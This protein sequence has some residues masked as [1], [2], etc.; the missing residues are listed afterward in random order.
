MGFLDLLLVAL[1]PVIKVLFI[2]GVGLFLALDHV[3]LLGPDAR[4]HLNKIVF[5]V[6]GPALVATNLAQTI[7]YE[8][9]VTL[10]FMPV[11]IL[12]TFM[13]GSAL[14]W[15]LI[16]ITRTP[17]HLQGMVIG[18]CS[19]GNLGNLPLIIVPSVCEESNNPFGESS[20]CF[21][22]AQAYASL[23]MATG[24]I[25]IWSYV[26]GIMRSYANNYKEAG[27]TININS[28]QKN[29]YSESDLETCREPLLPSKDWVAASDEYSVQQQPHGNFETQEKIS[30]LRKRFQCITMTMKKINLKEVFAPSA[31]AGMVGFFIGTVSP[32]RQ[33]LIGAD[34]PL[35][36]IENS[37]NLLG[38][39]T[40]ACMTLLVGAN[41]L[42]GLTRSDIRPSIIIGIIAVRNVFMP[43]LGIGVVNAAQHLGL[44]G[45]DALFQFVLMLQYA[46]PPAMAVGTM[47]QLFQ[48]G[49]SESSV[50]MLW[51]YVVAAFSLTLWSTV[52]MWL[53]F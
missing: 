12:L 7:T 17:K 45:T 50:I 40:V 6:F 23:S 36:V 31:I 5:Y 34:A 10:W 32:I 41:L 15:L 30:A 18:C 37:I 27:L 49:Q 33:I 35:R 28:S 1:I 42:K 11:N 2:T 48:M 44:V 24:A 47:T 9:L 14:A 26:Y 46:L 3:N 52:F 19:A 8:S 16:K 25:F 29:S 53:L 22:N 43:L 20:T 13:I 4:N 51:T 38:D 21:S 39:P